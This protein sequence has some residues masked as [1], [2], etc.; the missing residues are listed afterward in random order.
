MLIDVHG[1][2]EHYNF[3]RLDSILEGNDAEFPGRGMIRQAG[4]SGKNG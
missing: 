2:G 1:E 3:L 4:S